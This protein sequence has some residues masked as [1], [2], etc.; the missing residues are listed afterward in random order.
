MVSVL[1][2]IINVEGGGGVF[3]PPSDGLDGIADIRSGVC[4]LQPPAVDAIQR[5]QGFRAGHVFEAASKIA[6]PGVLQPRFKTG[7]RHGQQGVLVADGNETGIGQGRTFLAGG[8]VF[9]DVVDRNLR[10]G[11]IVV[12]PNN[13]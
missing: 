13:F 9:V 2:V 5:R 4:L 3:D 1:L 12:D 11:G 7:F 10:V 6:D 8:A